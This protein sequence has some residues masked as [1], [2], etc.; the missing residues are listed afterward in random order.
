MRHATHT[1]TRCAYIV[2]IGQCQSPS[3]LQ[4]ALDAGPLEQVAGW[5]VGAAGRVWI[6]KYEG[7]GRPIASGSV[8]R[9]SIPLAAP[10]RL[11]LR[12]GTLTA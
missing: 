12:H 9:T 1:V 3:G 5:Q 10:M 11:Y 8:R 2:H 4:R 6:C 7:G